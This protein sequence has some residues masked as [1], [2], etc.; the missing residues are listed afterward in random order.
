[1]SNCGNSVQK[2]NNVV[3]NVH[4]VLDK[5]ERGECTGRL[6][7]DH[8]YSSLEREYSHENEYENYKGI[9]LLRIAGKGCGK[10]AI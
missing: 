1:M 9:S 6:S 5:I 2:R 3:M 8:H 4:D 7:K 10:I